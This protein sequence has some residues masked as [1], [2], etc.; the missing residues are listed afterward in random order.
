VGEDIMEGVYAGTDYWWTIEDRFPL[1]KLFN[2]EFKRKYGYNPE[3]GANAAYMQ[4]AMWAD[5]VERAGTFNPPDV[6]KSYEKGVTVQSTVGPVHF[7]PED[8][9]LVRP[10]IIVRG[11]AQSKMKSKDDFY[12]LV[13]I[14][15]GA[16]LMQPPEAFGCKLGSYT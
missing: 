15:D 7:R 4:I 3:W 1:A 9:Q 13:E 10:V 12:D 14:V 16:A 2:D 5:A 8:H 11:K 6:I